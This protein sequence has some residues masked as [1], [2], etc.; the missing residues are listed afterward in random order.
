MCMHIPSKKTEIPS[1]KVAIYPARDSLKRGRPGKSPILILDNKIARSRACPMCPRLSVY[2]HEPAVYIRTRRHVKLIYQRRERSSE[3]VA[4]LPGLFGPFA[5]M[6]EKGIEMAICGHIHM[7]IRIWA[8]SCRDVGGTYMST[9]FENSTVRKNS[10]L[11]VVVADGFG[12]AY[13][14]VFRTREKSNLS[15]FIFDFDPVSQVFVDV[16]IIY[17]L[18]FRKYLK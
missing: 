16:C 13:K 2:A 11:D 6:S 10:W 15:C 4:C 5:R 1:A 18:H 14:K 8:V 3:A 9:S 17:I 7:W 12:F